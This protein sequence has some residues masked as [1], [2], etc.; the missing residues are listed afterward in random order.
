MREGCVYAQH[1]RCTERANE[2]AYKAVEVGRGQNRGNSPY[3]IM[4][5]TE[6]Q[7]PLS[8]REKLFPMDLTGTERGARG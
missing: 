4:R 6:N 5:R 1:R 3:Q 7:S 2:V 8:P